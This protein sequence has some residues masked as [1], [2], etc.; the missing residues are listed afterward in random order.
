MIRK[1]NDFNGVDDTDNHGDNT[2]IRIIE[3]LSGATPFSVDQD[4]VADPCMGI[5]QGDEITVGFLIFRHQG[6]DDQK[7]SVFVM[8]VT[9]C[10]H[11]STYNFSNDHIFDNLLG[12]L[13]LAGGEVE[14][15]ILIG[16]DFQLIHDA[17]QGKVY[18]DE[19][20]IP[21]GKGSLAGTNHHTQ[22]A[23]SGLNHIGGNL[24]AANGA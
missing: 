21:H 3:H 18:G 6:L 9:D 10:R 22:V 8:G 19:L 5:I 17:D 11:H 12:E 7:A 1:L 20:D 24:Q 23:Y 16:F 4:G 13:C 14:D 15:E 2:G